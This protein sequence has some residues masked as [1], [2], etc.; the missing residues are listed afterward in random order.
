MS[1]DV[2]LLIGTLVIHTICGKV[3]VKPRFTGKL[4]TVL[5]MTT[6]L[7]A[8]FKWDQTILIRLAAGAAVLTT[9][10]GLLYV[11]D[12]MQQLGASPASSA[13]NHKNHNS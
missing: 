11:K 2:L 4:S 7:W 3:T 8:L 6:I 13:V 10:S 5:Q 12:G 9:I 1:R